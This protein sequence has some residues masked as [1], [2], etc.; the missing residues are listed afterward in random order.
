MI[1]SGE[2]DAALRR[3][4]AVACPDLAGTEDETRSPVDD[5]V[6]RSSP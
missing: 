2:P 5:W 1:P 4:K 6:P 3:M